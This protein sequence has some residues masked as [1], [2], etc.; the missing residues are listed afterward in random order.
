[1]TQY[2][3]DPGLIWWKRVSGKLSG[4]KLAKIVKNSRT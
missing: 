4:K 1:M 2:V 3:S